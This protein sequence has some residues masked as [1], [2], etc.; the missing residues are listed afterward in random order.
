MNPKMRTVFIVCAGL[1]SFASFQLLHSQPEAG[2]MHSY[3]F[4]VLFIEDKDYSKLNKYTPGAYLKFQTTTGVFR[5]SATNKSLSN[6]FRYEGS[7]EL[8]FFEETGIRDRDGQP[9]RQPLVRCRMGAD[10]EK[11]VIIRKT[12]EEKYYSHVIDINAADF[13]KNRV[14]LFNLSDQPVRAKVGDEIQDLGSLQMA[15]YKVDTK[16]RR[17]IIALIIAAFDGENPYVVKKKKMLF[18]P[19]T[20]KLL[21]TYDSPR[22]PDKVI[23]SEFVL[24]DY[25]KDFKNISDKDLP[26]IDTLGPDEQPEPEYE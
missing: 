7:E 25:D 6:A 13:K 8:I 1:C 20:K 23:Y 21:L 4:R 5:I 10:G 2:T 24:S 3:V 26:E 19:D 9:M 16:G 11:I 12:V 15:E 22:D 14:R 18:R 17:P